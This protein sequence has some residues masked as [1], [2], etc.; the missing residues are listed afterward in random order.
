MAKRILPPELKQLVKRRDEYRCRYKNCPTWN[1]A[2]PELNIH[3]V[4]P[5]KYGGTDDPS[6]LV[7]FCLSHHKMAH[8][9]FHAYYPDSLRAV[10]KMWH[11]AQK[12]VT[13]IESSAR[14]G[15]FYDYKAPLQ[16][17]T[18]HRSFRGGQDEVFHAIQ[19]GKDVLFVAPTGVG[20]SVTYQLPG[21]LRAKPT[22]VISPLK[23]LMKDQVQ[24]LWSKFIPSTYI[25]SD[26][27]S[28]DMEN[29]VKMI[30]KGLM[31]FVY[32]APERYFNS[33]KS[34]EI[35]QQHYGLL[36]IDEAHCIDK[37]GGSFRPSYGMIG[38]MRSNLHRP[39]TIAVTASAS[40]A[41]QDEIIRSL[42]L[43]NP[44]R[45]VK[46][47]LRSN[48]EIITTPSPG[49]KQ[50]QLKTVVRDHLPVS[51]KTIF[52]V[53]SR[54]EGELLQGLLS[55]YG[56]MDVPFYF[57]QMSAE[58]RGVI[59][60][61]FSGIRA[62]DEIDFVIATS[63]FGMGIDVPNVRLVVHWN[64]PGTIEDYYQQ[65]GRAG[66]NGKVSQ[67]ILLYEAGDEGLPRY[68]A[69]KGIEASTVLTDQEILIAKHR[70][71]E[72]IA[73]MQGIID[74]PNPWGYILSYFGDQGIA[75]SV[76]SWWYKVISLFKNIRKQ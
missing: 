23:S 2:H 59:Q 56:L 52:Y 47:F 48:I 69:H 64:I 28:I 39:Q 1:D 76:F 3:H 40:R 27:G 35:F 71:D 9:D 43:Q 53:A 34:A 10:Q 57:G 6:N 20:K 26:L 30:S 62:N 63:A 18:G 66:R 8:I 36:V 46:G 74:S 54:K 70:A 45:I 21:L 29:R 12:F 15:E 60:D 68:I 24:H 51:G 4:L 5:E 50:H 7:T 25:N 22:L 67:A 44:V 41:T 73:L 11:H 31:K 49:N 38:E 65:I 55:Q 75:G 58:A 16:Y 33:P 37:W 72:E 42:G 32:L 13:Q 17:L 19:Q 14:F 61:R